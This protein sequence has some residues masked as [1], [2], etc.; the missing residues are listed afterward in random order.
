MAWGTHDVR[1]V[2]QLVIKEVLN[3]LEILGLCLGGRSEET[4]A[5][6]G[7]ILKISNERLEGCR[8]MAVHA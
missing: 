8:T 5:L 2:I 1:Q 4:N 6:C 3:T 7:L